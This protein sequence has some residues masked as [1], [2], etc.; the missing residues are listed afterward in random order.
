MKSLQTT[1]ILLVISQTICDFL[2]C[3][4]DQIKCDI[5][6]CVDKNT[7]CPV[8]MSCPKNYSQCNQFSCNRFTEEKCFIKNCEKGVVCWNNSCADKKEDCPSVISCPKVGMTRC[9]DNSCVNNIDDCFDYKECPNFIPVKC[10]NGNCRKRLEDCPQESKCPHNLPILCN[11]SSANFLCQTIKTCPIN[12][13]KCSNEICSNSLEDC[14]KTYSNSEQSLCSDPLK[15]RC[16]V[17]NSCV[18]NIENCPTG[19]ICPLSIPVKCWD[20]SCKENINNCPAFYPCPIGMIECPDG[21]CTA[22]KCGTLIT[23]SKDSPYKCYD[24]TCRKNPK[25][26]PT[27]KQC[28]SDRPYFCW[29][30]SCYRKREECQPPKACNANTPVRCSDNQCRTS[31]NECKSI[32]EC[33]Y[34]FFSLSDGSC[35]RNV[36]ENSTN[37][38][39]GPQYPREYPIRCLDGQCMRSSSYCQAISITDMFGNLFK[40]A[41]GKLVSDLNSCETVYNCPSNKFKCQDNSCV[42]NID[43][44]K[45]KINTCPSNF[46][47]RCDNGSCEK[48]SSLCLNISGCTKSFPIKCSDSG[49][50]VSN[51]EECT[52]VKKEFNLSNG[53]TNE[54][55][56]KCTKGFIGKC[57]NDQNDCYSICKKDEFYSKVLDKCLTDRRSIRNNI[58]ASDKI[59]CTDGTCKDKIEDC[60]NKLGC[61]L[62][63]PYRCADGLCKKETLIWNEKIENKDAC[64]LNIQCPFY[65][66]YL[67]ADGSCEEKKLFCNSIKK[68]EGDKIRDFDRNCK[69]KSEIQLTKK[70]PPSNPLL[71]S[72]TS[73]CV[74]SIYDC[75]QRYCPS[76][77]PIM[78]V[79]GECSSNPMYCQKSSIPCKKNEIMCYDGSCRK[80]IEYCPL[81]KGCSDLNFPFKCNDGSCA[82]SIHLCNDQTT[83]LIEEKSNRLLLTT[84]DN[85]ILCEDGICR[86]TCPIY[87]GCSNDKP[88]LCSNGFCV[89]SIAECAG[90]SNCGLKNP[91]RCK[92]GSC[93]SSIKDCNLIKSISSLNEE[94]LFTSPGVKYNTEFLLSNKNDILGRIYIPENAFINKTNS[95]SIEMALRLSTIP[96]SEL[97]GVGV[98][99]SATRKNDIDQIYPFAKY[100]NNTLFLQYEYSILSPVVKVEYAYSNLNNE[101]IMNKPIAISLAYDFPIY[102]NNKNT[103]ILD[104]MV[105]VCLGKLNLTNNRFNCVNLTSFTMEYSYLE[106]IG[107][108]DDSGIYAVMLSP[109]VDYSLLKFEHNFLIKNFI[110]VTIAIASFFVIL[111][112]IVYIFNK[113]Y[114]YRSKYIKSKVNQTK[115]KLHM[116]Q[117]NNLLLNIPSN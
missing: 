73:I 13:I 19:I 117:I 80:S 7:T 101:I 95:N 84:C 63:A 104:P 30:G 26:C 40:C 71:C 45:N 10:P 99:F 87:N 4:D 107:N 29:D 76:N 28:S 81:Y 31:V 105:D 35:S 27:I 16:A 77:K 14:Y 113:V 90:I 115:I 56:I 43:D 55:P 92:D 96:K 68:C 22:D 21:T 74:S 82:E 88:L 112:I 17:D 5:G 15:V 42:E 44:C 9:S 114:A 65:R 54:F 57:V 83:K 6:I 11:C 94:V 46:P 3:S 89:K 23:C 103:L 102:Y 100:A 37:L 66:P 53:C 41:D 62:S 1:I 2:T 8:K 12:M 67:C 70:C 51:I 106:L 86:E 34:G 50:C 93:K 108:I 25:D 69:E 97:L 32:S 111:L 49:L 59:E 48:D 79:N 18:D 91:F 24:N 98:E 75:D 72:E 33:P 85:L 52:S 47:Y 64:A 58:C 116:N 110:T 60:S 109:S 36:I 39:N 20:G 78:C 61:P 38:I